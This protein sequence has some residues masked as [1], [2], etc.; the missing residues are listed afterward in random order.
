MTD[1]DITGES[2]FVLK[3]LGLDI[4]ALGF[5]ISFI[6]VCL[7]NILLDHIL[8][9]IAWCPSNAIF[10]LYF[11]GRAKGHWDGGVSDWLM[12]LNYA[13][14]LVSGVWGLKQAG[15]W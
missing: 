6:G 9:M 12:C 5:V 15:V 8:A 13:F 2:I 7:N 14:M 11:F 4:A 3:D 10:C 1:D